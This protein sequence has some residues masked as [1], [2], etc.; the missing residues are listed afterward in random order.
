[1]PLF[2][3]N[4]LMRKAYIFLIL[5]I[6]VAVVPQLG[7]PYS[8]KDKLET[9]SGLIIILVSFM[10]YN[11]FKKKQVKKEKAFENFSENKF[12]AEDKN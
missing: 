3:Y 8:W 4:T 6:W 11:D 5:G 9:I 2:C 7:F 1:M 10:L 12:V